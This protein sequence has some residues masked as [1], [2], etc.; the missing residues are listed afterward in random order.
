MYAKKE[1][2]DLKLITD[3]M[4]YETNGEAEEVY[5][6]MGAEAHMVQVYGR[7]RVM[8]SA[9]PLNTRK[10]I[11]PKR[12]FLLWQIPTELMDMYLFIQKDP[13]WSEK[14]R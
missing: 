3:E 6:R 10:L 14:K 5:R 8:K 7:I 12:G 13:V 2:A 11:T 9:G 1:F 4:M